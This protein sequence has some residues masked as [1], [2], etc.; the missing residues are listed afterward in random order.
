MLVKPLQGR[1]R[2][3]LQCFSPDLIIF[4]LRQFCTFCCYSPGLFFFFVIICYSPDIFILFVTIL[5]IFLLFFRSPH[6]FCDNPRRGP[7]QH[8]DCPISRKAVVVCN[9][10]QYS[11]DL[12]VRFQVTNHTAWTLIHSHHP[13][14]NSPFTHTHTHTLTHQHTCT[15]TSSV[16]HK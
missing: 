8:T 6:P 1:S 16:L 2:K 3:D 15:C 10:A 4:F 9:L 7:K 11:A 13:W 14:P 5:Y 12:P